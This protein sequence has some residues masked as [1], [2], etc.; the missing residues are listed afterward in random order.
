MKRSARE[1]AAASCVIEID[2]VFEA[3]MTSGASISSTCL[4][5]LSLSAWFSVAA[6]MTS[7]AL[8]RSS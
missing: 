1:V 5:I 8:F 3:M 4:R 2:E 6:S 7:C